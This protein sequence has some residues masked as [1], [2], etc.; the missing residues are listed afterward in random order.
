MK[1]IDPSYIIKKLQRTPSYIKEMKEW[2]LEELINHLSEEESK[3]WDNWNA[4]LLANPNMPFGDYEKGPLYKLKNL[5]TELAKELALRKGNPNV[6]TNYF[7]KHLH[8]DAK[9]CVEAAKIEIGQDSRMIANFYHALSEKG[10]APIFNSLK[11]TK[12]A[13]G[14]KTTFEFKKGSRGIYNQL[15]CP[16]DQDLVDYFLAEYLSDC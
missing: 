8:Q 4:I 7:I 13:E 15:K 16:K 2:H 1:E 11:T 12:L 9:T 3:F 6:E 10:L 14:L 5:K